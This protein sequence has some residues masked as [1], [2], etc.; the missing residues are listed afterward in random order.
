MMKLYTVQKRSI[1][2]IIAIVMVFSTFTP[3]G[4][5]AEE[6]GSSAEYA[7]NYEASEN[8]VYYWAGEAEYEST[9]NDELEVDGEAEAEEPEE[10]EAYEEDP[11][12]P[13]CGLLPPQEYF[14]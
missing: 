4:I 8:E 14:P 1:A 6:Y 11:E 12:E 5:F 7:G 2:A 3:V 13:G 9:E 10:Y